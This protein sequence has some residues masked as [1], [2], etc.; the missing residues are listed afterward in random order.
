MPHL[1][2]LTR[3][4]NH[5]TKMSNSALVVANRI[6]KEKWAWSQEVKIQN[7]TLVDVEQRNI[8]RFK[9][10]SIFEL[11][12][13]PKKSSFYWTFAA[14]DLPVRICEKRDHSITKKSIFRFYVILRLTNAFSNREQKR[15]ES[16]LHDKSLK[17]AGGSTCPL[18]NWSK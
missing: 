5:K 17:S 18:W 7:N 6:K 8:K 15:R 14:S 2:S 13:L 16:H 4:N 10:R 1:S 12:L 9:R 3:E 11:T